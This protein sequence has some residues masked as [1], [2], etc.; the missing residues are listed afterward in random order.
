MLEAPQDLKPP[1][2]QDPVIR[3]QDKGSRFVILENKDYEEKIQHQIDRSS[4]IQLEE[5]PSRE[6]EQHVNDWIVK[7]HNHKVM[8][9]KWKAYITANDS[10]A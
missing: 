7:W 8:D 3:V 2:S 10:N 6:F 1:L 5:D 4:F 9:D